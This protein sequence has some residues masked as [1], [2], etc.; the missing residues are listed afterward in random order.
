MEAG[1]LILVYNG[2]QKALEFAMQAHAKRAHWV[3]K[4][5]ARQD[6][7]KNCKMLSLS[8]RVCPPI[9]KIET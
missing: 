8:Y 3:A 1:E 6:L 4:T 2:K 5:T 9:M 7:A